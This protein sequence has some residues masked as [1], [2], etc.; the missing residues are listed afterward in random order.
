[1][2][3]NV[4]SSDSTECRSRQT[5]RKDTLEDEIIPRTGSL[6]SFYSKIFTQKFVFLIR[7][8]FS[9]LVFSDIVVVCDNLFETIIGMSTFDR[10]GW[11]SRQF[12]KSLNLYNNSS[13]DIVLLLFLH[14]PTIQIKERMQNFSICW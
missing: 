2:D 9:I 10:R 11:N 6:E 4:A 1:M 8:V 13:D 14:R 12:P 7:E 5:L 3:S